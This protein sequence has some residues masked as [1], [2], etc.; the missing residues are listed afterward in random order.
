MN[1]LRYTSE[2]K[3]NLRIAYPVMLGQLGHVLV[4]LAD[5]LMVGKLGAPSLAAVSLGNG[6]IFIALS[7]GIG[8]TFAITPLIAEADGEKNVEKGRSYFQ[9]G[10]FLSI[11]L[12]ILLFLVLLLAKPVLY[13]MKQPI[14]VVELAVPY[15][16][17]VAFSMIPLMIFQGFKQFAD[18]LSLTKYAMQA[19]IIA[20]IINVIFNYLLIYGIWVFP[21]MGIVGAAYGTLF[22]RFAMLALLIVIMKSK[23]IF[24][25]YLKGFS[26]LEIKEKILQRIFNLGYPTALQMWF[27]VGIFSSGIFLAGVIGTKAQAANQIALNLASMTFMI[28][29]GLGVTATIRVGNQKGLKNY[30]ELR[31]IALS[32]FVLMA[33]I[34]LLFAGGFILMKNILPTFY[35][36]DVE[37]IEVAATLIVIAGFFQLSDG[38]QAVVLGALRGLQ[39][40][41]IPMLI[42]FVAYWVVGFPIC[43]YLSLKTDLKA[44]GIWIGLLISLTVSAILLYIRFHQLTKKLIQTKKYNEIT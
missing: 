10:V 5:N 37:V 9:H 35:I 33:A 4:G 12:G 42:T 41:K 3:Q 19:T 30:K 8:F 28:A 13:Y 25:P 38:I 6:I 20:N 34:D 7:L 43:Y 26:L 27:E 11:I 21:K 22:S 23:A 32:I 44:I 40:V 17:V 16:E 1:L 14:E 24:A 39:D 36:H 2:F 15:F 31:R 18:G 29:V